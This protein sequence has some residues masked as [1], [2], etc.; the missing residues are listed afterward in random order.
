VH[1]AIVVVYP[2]HI[3]EFAIV[4]GHKSQGSSPFN[5]HIVGDDNQVMLRE[6][7]FPLRNHSLKKS[8]NYRAF[9][10]EWQIVLKLAVR[11]VPFFANLALHEGDGVV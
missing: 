6:E 8:W 3:F 9:F 4:H 2:K 11:E 10:H 7:R 5:R 1:A